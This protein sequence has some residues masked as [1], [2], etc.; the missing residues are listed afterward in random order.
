MVQGAAHHQKFDLSK[1]GKNRKN[2][3]SN[4]NEIILLLCV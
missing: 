1:F 3:F 2:I 4:I